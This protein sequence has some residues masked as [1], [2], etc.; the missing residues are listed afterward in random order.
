MN[1]KNII[2]MIVGIIL[3]S[4]LVVLLLKQDNHFNKV[5]TRQKTVHKS[6]YTPE[7]L[8][9]KEKSELNIPSNVK[10]QVLKKNSDGK[11]EI[12]KIIRHDWDVVDD[13]SKIKSISPH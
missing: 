12:Y 11:V 10:V 2:I 5:N 7:F 8:S 1:K 13:L 4:L 3:I 9:D 6:A